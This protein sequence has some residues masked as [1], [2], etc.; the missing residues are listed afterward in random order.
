MEIK[1]STSIIFVPNLKKIKAREDV[2]TN[3]KNIFI[4]VQRRRKIRRKSGNFQEQIS[5]EP[6][7]QSTSNLV[8]KVRYVYVEHKICKFGRNPLS[9]F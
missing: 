9:S 1:S 3:F 8:C 2:F 7:A 5:H 6:L 4:L